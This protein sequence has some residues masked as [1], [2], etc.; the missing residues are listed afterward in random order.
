MPRTGIAGSY[1]SSIFSF[2]YSENY[3]ML[4]K[5]FK[6]YTNRWKDTPCSWT[7]RTNIVKITILSKEIYRFNAINI[8]LPITFFMN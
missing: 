5:E 1:S 8:K 7:G 6:E 2:L 4:I 3:K